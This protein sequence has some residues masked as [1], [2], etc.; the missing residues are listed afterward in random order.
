MALCEFIYI[1][2]VISHAEFRSAFRLLLRRVNIPSVLWHCFLGDRKGIQSVKKIL[3]DL[4]QRFSSWT[5]EEGNQL[6]QVLQEKTVKTETGTRE[7]R[8]FLEA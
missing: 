5:L 4:S 7:K 1:I 2:F 3:Y 8:I 6:T